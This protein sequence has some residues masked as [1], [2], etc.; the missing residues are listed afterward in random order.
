[1]YIPKEFAVADRAALHDLIDAYSFGQLVATMA[2]GAT[3]AAHIPF[4]LDRAR[5]AHGTLLAHVA[6]A[7]PICQAFAADREVLAMFEGPHSYVSP[8][9]YTAQRAVP[10]WNFAAVHAYGVPTLLDDAGAAVV[11]GRLSAKHEAGRPQPWSPDQV[12]AKFL[13][14]MRQHIV[15][16]EIPIAR[17]QGKFKMSQNRPPEDRLRVIAALKEE[18]HPDGLAVAAVMEGLAKTT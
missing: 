4:L 10:T 8:R 15:A 18:A 1:M 7:N 13:A 16:F 11:V 5:G 6:H 9:W 14:G 3:E 2:D 12:D 17:L